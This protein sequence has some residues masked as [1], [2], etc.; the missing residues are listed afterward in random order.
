MWKHRVLKCTAHALLPCLKGSTQR[1]RNFDSYKGFEFS[2]LNFIQ[3]LTFSHKRDNQKQKYL[4][5]SKY[6]FW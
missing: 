5:V 4:F 1:F 3:L 6:H 2:E